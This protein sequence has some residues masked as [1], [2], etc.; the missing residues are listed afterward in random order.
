MKTCFLKIVPVVLLLCASHFVLHSQNEFKSGNVLLKGGNLLTISHGD[1]EETDLL[2]MDGKIAEIGKDLNP[3]RN[4]PVLDVS[5]MYVMPGI[6]DAHSHVG[7]DAVNEA[8]N[9]ITAEVRIADVINPYDIALYH[10]LAGGV[11][12]S[13]AMH[14]SANVI[15]GQNQTIK[16]RYGTQ[17]PNELIMEG[18]ARTIKFALGE[19]P[20]RV[21]GE[22]AG[23]IPNTRMG[24]ET[25]I[26]QG[27]D[28]ALQYRRDWEKYADHKENGIISKPPVYDLRLE[29]LLEILDGEIM[30]HCHSYRSDEIYMLMQVCKD[31]GVKDLVFQ[32]VNEGFKVAPEL[33]EFGAM[34]SVFSDWWAYKFEVYYSTAYNTTILAKNGV[35]TSVNSDSRE[36][37]RHLYLEAAKAQRYGQ[38]SDSETLKLITLNPAIQ[39]GIA[40]RVGTLEVGKDGDVAVFNAHP[41]SIYAIPQYTFVDG[42]KYFDCTEDPPDMRVLID[43]SDDL[44]N[45]MELQSGR[46]DHECLH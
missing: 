29:A 9:P 23:I 46:G 4:I 25:V 15:G 10:A 7:L 27:F 3:P 18:A 43:I 41:L 2:I 35:I 5:G 45:F 39:L 16:H 20:M 1:M 19:N 31:Y 38:L 24:V 26:R 30:I 37:I 11:T 34:A 36:L 8:T 40:D 6:V 21:H 13:H 32:H 28:E 14:G 12:V 44:N 22:G 33:A 17:D 42:I